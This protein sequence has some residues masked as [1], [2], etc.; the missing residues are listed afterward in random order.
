MS[1]TVL[2]IVPNHL[3]HNRLQFSLVQ[4]EFDDTKDDIN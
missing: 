2:Y 1:K 4:E 3:Q